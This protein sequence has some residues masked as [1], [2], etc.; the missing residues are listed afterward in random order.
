MAVDTAR[1][2]ALPVPAT[3]PLPEERTGRRWLLIVLL[4]LGLLITVVPF[5]WMLR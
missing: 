3:H 4:L 1:H 2:R 5:L